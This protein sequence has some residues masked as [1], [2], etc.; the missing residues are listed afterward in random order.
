MKYQQELFRGFSLTEVCNAVEAVSD[1]RKIEKLP[2]S[3]KFEPPNN[4][5]EFVR[6]EEGANSQVLLTLYLV[7]IIQVIITQFSALIS[8]YYSVTIRFPSAGL[9]CW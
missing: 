5:L 7:D 8:C 2:A 1:E 6:D 4:F 3:L 9:P